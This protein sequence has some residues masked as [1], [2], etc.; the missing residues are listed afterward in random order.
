MEGVGERGERRGVI[1]VGIE[2]CVIINYVKSYQK[3]TLPK[4]NLGKERR[5]EKEIEEKK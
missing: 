2:I 4:N 3:G 1:V 5:K